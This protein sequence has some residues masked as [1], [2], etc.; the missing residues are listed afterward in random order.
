MAKNVA[1][2]GKTANFAETRKKLV[3]G[4]NFFSKN[5]LFACVQTG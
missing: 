1:D 4:E 5:A 2:G 3:F